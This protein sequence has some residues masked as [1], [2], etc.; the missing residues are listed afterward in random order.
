V[1]N[2]DSVGDKA[3]HKEY[4]K[5]NTIAGTVKLSIYKFDQ[6]KNKE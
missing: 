5:T 3:Q 1:N 2:V 4:I 6:V